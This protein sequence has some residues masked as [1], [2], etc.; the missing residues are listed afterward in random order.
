MSGGS[1]CVIAMLTKEG[2]YTLSLHKRPGERAHL[3][4]FLDT[5]AEK[6]SHY[7][8]SLVDRKRHSAR[9]IFRR[10]QPHR[11]QYLHFSGSLSD[12]RGRVRIISR[13]RW[14][15]RRGSVPQNP[16]VRVRLPAKFARHG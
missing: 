8:L 12:N 14:R 10:G 15:N 7:Y 1:R 6:L 13:G 3:D 5:G 9:Q 16:L 2:R 4:L 11:Q